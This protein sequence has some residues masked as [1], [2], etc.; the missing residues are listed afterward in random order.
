[1][2]YSVRVPLCVGDLESRQAPWCSRVYRW[3][4]LTVDNNQLLLESL[5]ISHRRVKLQLHN[6]QYI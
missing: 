2:S 5:L 4:S 1:M 3:T 6:T